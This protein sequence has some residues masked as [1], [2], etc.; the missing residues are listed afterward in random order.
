MC[1]KRIIF[2]CFQTC[3]YLEY[4]DRNVNG[5][6][7]NFL[8]VFVNDHNEFKKYIVDG[9]DIDK[10]DFTLEEHWRV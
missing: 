3:T 4:R 6:R 2:G 8:C 1:L 9:Y 5:K 7:T 10:R